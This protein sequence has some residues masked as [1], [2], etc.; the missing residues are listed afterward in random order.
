M[1]REEKGPQ[2]AKGLLAG[3]YIIESA[4]LAGFALH[5]DPENPAVLARYSVP[6]SL[7][8]L[9]LGLPAPFL[10]ALAR[11]LTRP[12]RRV[13]A[14]G[15]T[16]EISP[17]RKRAY[18]V[19]LCIAALVLTESYFQVRKAMQPPGRVPDYL[20]GFHPHLQI[21][22][23]PFTYSGVN[24]HGFRG[25]EI[26]RAKAP[27]VYRIFFL[28]GSTTFNPFHKFE[29]TYP[30]RFERLLRESYP[31]RKI[32]VQNAGMSWYTSQH[33]LINFLTRVQDFQPDLVIVCHAINDLVRSFS[34]SRFAIS[35]YGYR[36][37]YSHFLGPQAELFADLEHQREPGLADS[38]VI[39]REATRFFARCYASDLRFRSQ[40]LAE[41]DVKKFP[42]LNA[43]RRNLIN[44]CDIAAA[45]N[46]QLVLVTQPH[47]YTDDLSEE[48]RGVL[49]FPKNMGT[50]GSRQATG[51]SMK[52]GIE[53][54]NNATRDLARRKGVPLADMENAV[55]KTLDYFT[56]EVHYTAKGTS[57]LASKMVEEI[58]RSGLVDQ[59]APSE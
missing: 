19:T 31:E 40:P 44:L 7:F 49:W 4:L 25:P 37:D 53:M 33:S 3:L 18:L 56:D 9:S 34:P 52:R 59:G 28:G 35:G 15:R 20:L 23:H 55:P 14:D 13:L 47:L 30:R 57:I 46:V 5:T 10:P 39:L 8:L 51:A 42:S 1:T 48:E 26:E 54:F 21:I 58:I 17:G 50:D 2:Q 27:G 36:S 11:F 22:P 41:W 38:V 24:Q 43:F 16:L 32:E 6:Y 29:E 45:R 12:S